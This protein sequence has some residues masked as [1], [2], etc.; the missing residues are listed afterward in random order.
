MSA[1]PTYNSGRL[2]AQEHADLVW[3][4]VPLPSV[5][6]PAPSHLAR[7]LSYLKARNVRRM[8]RQLNEPP[9]DRYRWRNLH[10]ELLGEQEAPTLPDLPF[11]ADERAC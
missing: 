1:I 11:E 7:E 3:G 9:R 4:V 6:T 8:R 10:A 2:T 5:D